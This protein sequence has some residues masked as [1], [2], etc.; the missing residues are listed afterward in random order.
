MIKKILPLCG[1]FLLAAGAF[2]QDPAPLTAAQKQLALNT[3][4]SV[5]IATSAA[6]NLDPDMT[7][8]KPGTDPGSQKFV[9][10]LNLLKSKTQSGACQVQHQRTSASGTDEDVF[11]VVGSACLISYTSDER[12]SPTS[13]ATYTSQYKV[14]DSS[15]AALTDVDAYDLTGSMG[16]D[17]SG[18]L[19]IQAKGNVHSQSLG[20]LAYTV[21]GAQQ[22]DQ[23]VT[24]LE[25]Q[26]PQ[27][28]AVVAETAEVQGNTTVIIDA[29]NG[30]QL[31]AQEV[32]TYLYPVYEPS[33]SG[34]GLSEKLLHRR[35]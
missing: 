8:G 23:Y 24:T 9:Q 16:S 19:L 15:Y 6:D 10:M 26:F 13:P 27:F 21:S 18:N 22:G 1:I 2:A 7:P 33:D 3:F 17:A 35:D 20:E 25:V 32:Q 34:Q 29:L 31:T 12:A 28:V 30:V 4:Q 5:V 11:N 14:I